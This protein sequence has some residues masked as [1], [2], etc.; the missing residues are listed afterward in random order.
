M[1]GT[2]ISRQV[3]GHVQKR[4]HPLEAGFDSAL[5]RIAGDS[6]KE[7]VWNGVYT[8]VLYQLWEWTRELARRGETR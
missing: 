3:W 2:R 5:E 8:P 1:S 6:V 7:R 4:L